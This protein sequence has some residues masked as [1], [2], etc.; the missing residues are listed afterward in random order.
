MLG[1]NFGLQITP[2]LFYGSWHVNIYFI[3][4]SEMFKHVFSADCCMFYLKKKNNFPAPIKASL[5][6]FGNF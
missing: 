6:T 2:E 4:K 1:L 3:R 5:N